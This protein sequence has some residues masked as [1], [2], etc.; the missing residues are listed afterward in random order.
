MDGGAAAAY[1]NMS[2]PA[3]SFDPR[4][5]NATPH[6]QAV[7]MQQYAPQMGQEMGAYA[8]APAQASAQQM[9]MNA[10]AQQDAERLGRT[11]QVTNVPTTMT[12]DNLVMI[13][14]GMF[15]EVTSSCGG[16]DAGTQRHFSFVEFKDPLAA[17]KALE[18]HMV[19]F[20]ADS[21]EI[22]ASQC[23][24]ENASALPGATAGASGLPADSNGQARDRSRSRGRQTRWGVQ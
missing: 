1:D 5:Q 23:L 15:G 19:Q 16:V 13:L 6:A 22:T 7:H 24:V 12:N 20:G 9:E 4:L 8:T 10:K 3:Y 11:V 2:V 18:A 21:L 17:S 14:T